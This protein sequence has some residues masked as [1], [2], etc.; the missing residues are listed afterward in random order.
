[1]QRRHRKRVK[2]FHEPGDLHELTFSCYRRMP[3]LTNDV[4]RRALS[5]SLTTA[6]A[7]CQVQLVASVFMPEHVHLLVNPLLPKPDVSGLLRQIK[8]PYSAEIHQSFN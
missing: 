1:M 2:H 5:R 6:L 4:W 7:E 3:L 8:Q